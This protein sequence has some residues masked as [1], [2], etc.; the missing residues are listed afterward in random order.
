[1]RQDRQSLQTDPVGYQD[2]FN[3]Y[4]YAGNSPIDKD[5][6]SGM[7]QQNDAPQA[8]TCSRVGDI[9]CSGDYP[10]NPAEAH[11]LDVGGSFGGQGSD[12]E[13]G[14]REAQLA[15]P[16]IEPLMRIAPEVAA[17]PPVVVRPLPPGMTNAEFGRTI[18]WGQSLAGATRWLGRIADPRALTE[19]REGLQRAGVTRDHLEGIRA[20]Y[21][22][23][24]KQ[25]PQPQFGQRLQG[26]D[27][28]L[29]DYPPGG[30]VPTIPGVIAPPY[31]KVA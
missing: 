13:R 14:K 5:D 3:L 8:N 17:R 18:G 29:E 15:E 9:S 23:A 21:E 12:N 28:I 4:A 2:D 31:Q 10:A 16:L 7:D 6:P 1:V 11:A 20:F 26:L 27:K 30:A 19:V 25:N 24:F 22:Q